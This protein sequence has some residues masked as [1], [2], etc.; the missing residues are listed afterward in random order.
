MAVPTVARQRKIQLWDVYEYVGC[1]PGRQRR[2]RSTDVDDAVDIQR[3]L[4]MLR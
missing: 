2:L 4:T 1:E 3:A